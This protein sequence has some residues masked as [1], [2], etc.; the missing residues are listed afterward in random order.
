[1]ERRENGTEEIWTIIGRY[2]EC[3]YESEMKLSK[4]RVDGN[5][6]FDEIE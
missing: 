5:L 2:E 4:Q 6:S 1:M 3:S